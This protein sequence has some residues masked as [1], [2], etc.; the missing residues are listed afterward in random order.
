MGLFDRL[1]RVVRA[2]LNDMVSKAEDP[3]KILEQAVSDMQEDLVQLRQAVARAIAEQRQTEQKYSKEQSEANKWEQRAKLA[4]SK[5]DETL[6]R[7]A[8]KRK[9]DYTETAAILKNQLDQQ[10]LQVDSLRKNLIALESKISE[11]KTKKNMLVAR[12]RAAKANEELQKTLGGI[13]TSG[14]MSAFE[15]MEEKVMQLEA[16]SQA[17]GELGGIGI[18]QEFAKLEAGSDVDDEL[19]LLKA[20]MSGGAL[21]G[22]TSSQ[23]TL[24][25]A[26]TVSDSAVDAEL[27]ELRSKLKEL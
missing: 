22:T 8:L 12:S 11:A 26:T 5:G 18:E 20:Q 17:Y 15:R 3:E 7:E 25:Q 4:L 21:P 13:D 10:T 2:N 6:A 23:P 19:A 24:P 16:S 9:K 1:S 27:E 14:S